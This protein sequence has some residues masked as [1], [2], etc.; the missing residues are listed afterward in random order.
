[1]TTKKPAP[2]EVVAP[3]DPKGY[4]FVPKGAGPEEIQVKD[5]NLANFRQFAFGGAASLHIPQYAGPQEVKRIQKARHDILAYTQFTFPAYVADPF[6]KHMARHINRVV[7]IRAD[8]SPEPHPITNLMLF[9]PP[10]HGKSEMVSVRLSS[11]W[12]A[13][14]PDLPVLLTSYAAS[15]AHANSAKARSVTQTHLY[16]QLFGHLIPDKGNWRREDWHFKDIPAY[17][18]A[19][20]VGGPITGH[21]FGLGVIDDP[22]ESWEAAQSEAVRE[23]VWEWWKGTFLTRMWEHSRIVLMMTRWKEDD[24]AGR[25]LSEEGRVEEGGKWT[26]LSYSALSEQEEPKKDILHRPYDTALAPKRFSTMFLRD[27]RTRVGDLVWSAEYQQHPSPPQ[28]T[29]YRIGRIQIEPALPVEI[30]RLVDGK[31]VGILHGI[32]FWDLAASEK[33]SQKRDPDATCG[34]LMAPDPGGHW[35][36]IDQVWGMWEPGQVEEMIRMTAKLDGPGVLIRIETEPGASGISLVRHYI[37][38]LAGYAVEG[39]P[40]SGDKVTWASPFASQVNVGNV[41]FLKGDWNKPCL[42]DMAEFPNAKHDD[43][44]DS[45]AG[46]FNCLTEAQTQFKDVKFI[47]A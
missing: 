20:G 23:N 5:I 30:G 44:P 25:I 6:H 45:M 9:A 29:F 37:T 27:V 33:K 42:A 2:S 22:Y 10:Q 12:L 18:F 28:G 11:Y 16:Q 24:L 41:F 3:L 38:L 31:P 47:H 35:W 14:H 8:G 1:M 39:V 34:S 36:G 15:R 43:R 26:V 19:A 4:R 7:G 46:A 32:R 21:G 17:V 13:H 40:H